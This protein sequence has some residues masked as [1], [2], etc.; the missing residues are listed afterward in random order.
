MNQVIH[1]EAMK[2]FTGTHLDPCQ[3]WSEGNV[4]LL[5][6]GSPRGE[7]GMTELLIKVASVGHEC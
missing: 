1:E 7:Q 4:S 5:H 6:V 3:V 2:T